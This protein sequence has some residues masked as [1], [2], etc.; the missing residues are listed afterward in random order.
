MPAIPN[1]IPQRSNLHPNSSHPLLSSFV[2]AMFCLLLAQTCNSAENPTATA[3]NTTPATRPLTENRKN[4]LLTGYDLIENILSGEA[5]LIYLLWFRRLTLRP[6]ASGVEQLLQTLD[7]AANTR[8]SQLKRLRKLSPPIT[9]KAPSSPIG[10]SIQNTA[11]DW[12]M[13]GMLVGDTFNI[14]FLFLQA[15]STRMLAVIANVTAGI[16]PNEDRKK[17][18]N[19]V[20]SE[21]EDLHSKLVAS[22]SKCTPQ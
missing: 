7:K 1:P 6:P 18:L 5:D 4:D 17:W 16:E 12:A 9:G 2:F 8:L 11:T 21:F 3:G 15:Q 19:E 14:R 20:S 10:T 13:K 22:L